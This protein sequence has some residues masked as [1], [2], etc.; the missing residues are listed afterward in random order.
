MRNSLGRCV[1][2]VCRAEGVVDV[3]VAEGGEA[4]GEFGIVLFFTGI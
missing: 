2:T 1:C 3:N 4:L